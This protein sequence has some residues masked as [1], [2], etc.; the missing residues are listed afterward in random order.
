M[1]YREALSRSLLEN[2]NAICSLFLSPRT[3]VCDLVFFV[4]SV[5]SLNLEKK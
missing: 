2:M 5:F 4:L 1:A 3:L